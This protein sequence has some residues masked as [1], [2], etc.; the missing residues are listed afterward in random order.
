MHRKSD[1]ISNG[2]IWITIHISNMLKN[3]HRNTVP[4]GKVHFKILNSKIISGTSISDE[5]SWEKVFANFMQHTLS[6][7][8]FNDFSVF[9]L[10]KNPNK[11]LNIISSSNLVFREVILILTIR[12]KSTLKALSTSRISS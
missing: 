11:S 12:K 6:S 9:E 3:L 2:G 5:P 4:F 7:L 8:S 1:V 10:N